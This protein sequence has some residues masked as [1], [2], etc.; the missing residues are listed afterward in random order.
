VLLLA[1]RA[2]EQRRLGD[3]FSLKG[4]HDSLLRNGSI[5]ISFQRRL[6]AAEA[7]AGIAAGS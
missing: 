7:A 1:L 4:F 3:R 6:L 2:D 5:P